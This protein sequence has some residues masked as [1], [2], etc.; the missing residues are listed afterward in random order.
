MGISH[1]H[2]DTLKCLVG[3]TQRHLRTS[4]ACKLFR[5]VQFRFAHIHR[6]VLH[7][8]VA[9]IEFQRL[10]AGQG[11]QPD[12]GLA[13]EPFLENVFADAPRCIA[14]H[15]R[16]AAVGIEDTHGEISIRTLRT[17]YQHQSVGSD[18]FVAVAPGDGCRSRVLYII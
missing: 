16:L 1:R 17:A 4:F 10:Y 14:A 15:T 7:M 12:F 2:K 5:T 8:S 18:A 11:E 3:H 6:H 13:G 9:H